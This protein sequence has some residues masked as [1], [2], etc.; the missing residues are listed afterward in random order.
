MGQYVQWD[1]ETLALQ[2]H[3]GSD[4]NEPWTALIEA[5]DAWLVEADE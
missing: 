4:V 2:I 5:L 3:Y 1:D